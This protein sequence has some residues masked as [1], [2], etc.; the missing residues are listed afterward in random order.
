GQDADELGVTT[1]AQISL[2]DVS[3][4]S[5]PRRVDTVDFGS[6]THIEGDH[7]AFL[8]WQPTGTIA[9]PVYGVGV[10]RIDF[11][12]VNGNNLTRIASV[13]FDGVCDYPRR[14]IAMGDQF[15]LVGTKRMVFV[16]AVSFAVTKELT[17]RSAESPC[18]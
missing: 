5:N 13:P 8:Y 1:G 2:F 4:P 15:V 11:V 14:T 3:V 16:D 17:L 9:V 7:H 6:G 12:R 10:S 18:W